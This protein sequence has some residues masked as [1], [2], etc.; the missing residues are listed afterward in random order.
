M[1]ADTLTVKSDVKLVPVEE[2]WLSCIAWITV[3]PLKA[4]VGENL[5]FVGVGGIFDA[6]DAREKL[7]AGASLL[8]AYTGFVYGGP[9]F[10]RHVL[11][12]L[13]TEQL[14]STTTSTA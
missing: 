13:L 4:D 8:Q 14:S 5:V 6:D 9:S 12:G 3:L 7:T 2:F 10:A 11:R 1:A